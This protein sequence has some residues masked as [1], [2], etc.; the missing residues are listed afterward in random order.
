MLKSNSEIFENSHSD[1]LIKKQKV[2]RGIRT[3]TWE[4]KTYELPRCSVIID[5]KR[6]K[7]TANGK[8]RHRTA[9]LLNKSH[10]YCTFVQRQ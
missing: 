9:N 4:D 8:S 7:N 10:K 2:V 1:P 3:Y 6:T 5:L